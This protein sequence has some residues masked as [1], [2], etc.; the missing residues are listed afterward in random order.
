MN[1]TANYILQYR[2]AISKST[3]P[4]TDLGPPQELKPVTVAMPEFMMI[5]SLLILRILKAL[6]ID[7]ASGPDRLPM[8]VYRE[9]CQELAPAIAV[10]VRFLLRVGFW[11]MIWRLHRIQPLYKKRGQFA[12]QLSWRASPKH[13]CKDCRT[14]DCIFFKTFL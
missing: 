6:K 11:P 13:S 4:A 5:R 1:K 12:L 8:R 9:C 3:L 2:I 10:R 7:T 14:S